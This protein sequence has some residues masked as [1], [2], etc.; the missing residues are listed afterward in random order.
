M[1]IQESPITFLI[2]YYQD[3]GSPCCFSIISLR[4]EF[5]MATIYHDDLS[6]KLPKWNENKRQYK[7]KFPRGI[8][9]VSIYVEK[10]TFFLGGL[11]QSRGSE[12]VSGV[13]CA[14]FSFDTIVVPNLAPTP[15]NSA[16]SLP[17]TQVWTFT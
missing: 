10:L 8:L 17:S 1:D 16:S 7:V 13:C 15:T 14:F 4:C 2:I 11:Q 12:R 3:C 9:L 5:A 6:S